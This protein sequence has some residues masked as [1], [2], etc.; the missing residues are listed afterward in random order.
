[1]LSPHADASGVE[2][3]VVGKPNSTLMDLVVKASGITR[4]R[5]CV[6]RGEWIGGGGAAKTVGVYDGTMESKQQAVLTSSCVLVYLFVGWG[7]PPAVYAGL[8]GRLSPG[9]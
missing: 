1:M 2:P 6:V 8:L 9:V 4:N 3:F 7:G 5:L